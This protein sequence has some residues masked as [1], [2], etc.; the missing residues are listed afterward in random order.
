MNK[1]FKQYA[2]FERKIYYKRSSD[3]N[4][5][6]D[7]AIE[8]VYNNTLPFLYIYDTLESIRDIGENNLLS[9]Y[10]PSTTIYDPKYEN[11]NN[12]DERFLVLASYKYYVGD[13]TVWLYDKLT[14][15]IF[16]AKFIDT[17]DPKVHQNKKFTFVIYPVANIKYS[18][19]QIS[20]L[21]LT[22]DEELAKVVFNN[23]NNINITDVSLVIKGDLSLRTAINVRAEINSDFRPASDISIDNFI[24]IDTS[25][26]DLSKTEFYLNTL[27]Q[28][29]HLQDA[30]TTT[31]LSSDMGYLYLPLGL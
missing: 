21:F 23:N 31:K 1:T 30:L 4:S 15:N 17:L 14:S 25:D 16:A 29:D 20:N 28:Y 6:S 26:I 19:K 3:D 11:D 2:G 22:S 13:S 8:L 7:P 5:S 12:G 18:T 24:K 27:F 10:S 9:S